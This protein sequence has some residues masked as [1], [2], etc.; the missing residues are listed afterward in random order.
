MSS[1]KPKNNSKN[2]KNIDKKG[3]AVRDKNLRNGDT[4]NYRK[5]MRKTLGERDSNLKKKR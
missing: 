2:S 3:C 1:V 5:S 4:K